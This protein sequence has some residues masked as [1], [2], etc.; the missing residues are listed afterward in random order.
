VEGRFFYLSVCPKARNKTIQAASPG[1]TI[2]VRAGTY[3]E[4]LTTLNRSIILT[5]EFYDPNDPTHNTTIIG[6]GVSSFLSTITVLAALL[7][8]TASASPKIR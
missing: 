1:D 6:G 2:I 8:G 3:F 7:A 5:A 4:N